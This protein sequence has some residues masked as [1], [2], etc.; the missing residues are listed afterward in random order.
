MAGE[1]AERSRVITV[2]PCRTAASAPR[3]RK[4][5]KKQHPNSETT[6]VEANQPSALTCSFRLCTFT[7]DGRA[8]PARTETRSAVRSALVRSASRETLLGSPRLSAA[9]RGSPGLSAALRGSPGLS[10]ALRCNPSHPSSCIH[11]SPDRVRKLVPRPSAR[12][13]RRG[14]SPLRGGNAR[15]GQ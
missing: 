10:G 2:G 15:W 3:G 4:L 8:A 11:S 12:T 5:V 6:S 14:R 7:C 1:R 9:L 13:E